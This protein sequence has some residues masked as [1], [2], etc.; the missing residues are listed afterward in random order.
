MR[1][2]P[3][4]IYLHA[5]CDLDNETYKR[6]SVAPVFKLSEF[7]RPNAMLCD[8]IPALWAPYISVQPLLSIRPCVCLLPVCEVLLA[9][10]LIDMISDASD[11]DVVPVCS[12]LRRKLVIDCEFVIC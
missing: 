7:E 1:V 9:A 11:R 12:K 10:L 2:V 8:Y 5:V 6:E 4:G 3:S